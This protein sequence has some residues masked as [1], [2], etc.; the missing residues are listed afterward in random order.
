MDEGAHEQG[1]GT[2]EVTANYVLVVG[3]SVLAPYHLEDVPFRVLH[4]NELVRET[5]IVENIYVLVLQSI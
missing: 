4:Q 3:V 5:H 2:H 1:I